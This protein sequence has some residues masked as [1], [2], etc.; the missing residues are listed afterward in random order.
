ML[1]SP[2]KKSTLVLVKQESSLVSWVYRGRA[3]PCLAVAHFN[4]PLS[5]LICRIRPMCGG[6]R[7]RE[8]PSRVAA[9]QQHVRNIYLASEFPYLGKNQRQRQRGKP[10]EADRERVSERDR[11]RGCEGIGKWAHQVGK[12]GG[13]KRILMVDT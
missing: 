11:G 13:S 7:K 6:K 1:D 3:A 9:A 5:G 8:F 2:I 4:L 12:V 10:R